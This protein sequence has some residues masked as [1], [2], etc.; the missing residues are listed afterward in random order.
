M[1]LFRNSPVFRYAPDRPVHVHL[2]KRGRG[3]G[4][5][6]TT[7]HIVH[8][9]FA[10]TSHEERERSVRAYQVISPNS[11]DTNLIYDFE[12]LPHEIRTCAESVSES[13]GA[14]PKPRS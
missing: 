11:I 1:R 13:A 8:F 14:S 2:P 9:K 3:L 4:R 6:L 5:R 7:G 12:S 10:L